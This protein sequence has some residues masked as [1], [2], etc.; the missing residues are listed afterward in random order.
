[1]AKFAFVFP[2]Q[3]SQHVGMAKNFY[4]NFSFVREI[5]EEASDS[6]HINLKKLCFEGPVERL[7]QT[8]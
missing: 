2:G 7:N 8:A 6:I 3:G 5:F 1:M 4:E